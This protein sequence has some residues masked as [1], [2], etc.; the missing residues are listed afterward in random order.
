[1]GADESL[2]NLFDPP[3]L[4]LFSGVSSWSELV[5]FGLPFPYFLLEGSFLS[6]V[7]LRFVGAFFLCSSAFGLMGLPFFGDSRLNSEGPPIQLP[8]MSG[9]KIP[10]DLSSSTYCAQVTGFSL[11][12]NFLCPRP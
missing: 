5:D 9:V 11:H 12:S 3:A 10:V 6:S 7:L 4:S 1:M 8:N 2:M